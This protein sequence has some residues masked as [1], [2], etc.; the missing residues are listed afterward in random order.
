MM[1]AS[2]SW[3]VA[4]ALSLFATSA[5]AQAPAKPRRPAAA[6]EVFDRALARYYAGDHAAASA[7]FWD[8][9]ATNEPSVDRHEWARYFLGLSLRRL[10]FSHGAAEHLFDVAKRRTLPEVLRETL[11]E[12]ELLLAGPHD[13][14][15]LGRSLLTDQDFGWLPGPAGDF[16]AHHKGVQDLRDERL[17][18]AERSFARI[19][20]ES[21]Y[22]ARATF[23]LGVERLKR[24]DTK[25]AVHAFRRTLAHPAA[26]RAVRN[27]ARLAL[28]R[29]LYDA[30]RWEAALDLYARV[31]VPELTAEEGA[32]LLEKAWTHYWLGRYAKAMG[33][34]YALEAPSYRDLHAPEKLLLRALI[35]EKLCHWVP[36]KR[37]IRRFTHRYADT[38]KAIRERRELEADEVLRR[39]ALGR[40]ELARLAA[41]RRRL[42]EEAS[43]IDDVGG[44]FAEV[45]LDDHLRE[46][47]GLAAARAD[48]RLSARLARETKTVARELMDLEEQ[49]N[50]LDYEIGLA[51]FR[52]LERPQAEATAAAASLEI[53]AGGPLA[54]YAFEDEFWNDEL[55]AYE[56]FIED[57][58]AGQGVKAP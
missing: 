18:W 15:L 41:F 25:A 54:Y 32:L 29:V 4:A 35:Y 49:M 50:L 30:E 37:E 26:D 11:G 5:A 16:L 8:Y 58:C 24:E 48:L 42:A 21:P 12:I 36:A 2:R 19:A 22:A 34:L 13:E 46:V 57:R 1:R 43:R 39:A 31:E 28:A 14:R 51:I 3:W 27:Q 9:L 23:A 17:D 56:L 45:G 40:G 52:R 44:A 7:G 20:P 38:L 10:G 55:S 33:L 47:Y 6:P 53:P